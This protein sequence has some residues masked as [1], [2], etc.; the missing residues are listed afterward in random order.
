MQLATEI[1]DGFALLFAFVALGMNIAT[2]RSL[3]R[4]RAMQERTRLLQEGTA[5]ILRDRKGGGL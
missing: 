2:M 3:K 4:T 5:K 1:L